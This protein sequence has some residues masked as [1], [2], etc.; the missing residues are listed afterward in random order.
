MAQF[1]NQATVSYNGQTVNSNIVT[2]ELTQALSATKTAT[3]DSY[4]PGDIINYVVTIQNTGT[5]PYTNLTVTDNMG[6]YTIGTPPTTTDVVPLTYTGDAVLYYINGIPQASPAVTAGPPLVI[7]GISVPAG[8][9]VTLVYRARAN[10]F[11][12]LGGGDAA[13][14]NQI[15]ITGGGL[16]E[17]V[18]AEESVVADT[19]ASL[20]IFK[21]L[22][23]STVVEN[24]PITY[25]FT[26]QNTGA[27]A[28]E[29]DG[30]L[31]ITDDFT[32]ALDAPITVTVDGAVLTQAGNYTYDAGTG[33]FSTTA[34]VI[35]VPAA[36]YTQNPTTGVW[37]V[38]P[39]VT[40]VTVTGTI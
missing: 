2:G 30:N 28:V 39:G 36:T 8:G 26:I 11:A 23:P 10:Q 27:T 24:G 22:S 33:L 19:A 5:T 4:R 1:T 13:I 34:G 29:A 21:E 3:V 32:P 38:T 31:V 40:V 16:N 37:T 18:T 6:A 35:T 17:A 9:T 20:S 14:D 15:S 7:T 12:P 25:T